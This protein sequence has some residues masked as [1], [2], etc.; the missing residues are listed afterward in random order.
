MGTYN[1]KYE[2]IQQQLYQDK[3]DYNKLLYKTT[4][5]N[6][7]LAMFHVKQWAILHNQY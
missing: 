5:F 1:Y 2:L 4:G 7:R 3:P 6:T